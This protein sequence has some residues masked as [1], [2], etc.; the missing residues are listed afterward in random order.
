M[1]YNHYTFRGGYMAEEVQIEI[2]RIMQ[3]S[4]IFRDVLSGI[5]Y[6]Y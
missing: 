3:L 4:G 5:G 2:G 1:T 6:E